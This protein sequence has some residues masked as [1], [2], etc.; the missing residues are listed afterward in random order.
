MVSLARMLIREVERLVRP[1]QP[2]GSVVVHRLLRSVGLG[3]GD[4]TPLNVGDGTG[5][6]RKVRARYGRSRYGNANYA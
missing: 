6:P 2:G 1:G 5:S 4:A 3:S